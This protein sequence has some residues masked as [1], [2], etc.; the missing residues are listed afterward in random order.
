MASGIDTLRK[1]ASDD[2][3]VVYERE[4]GWAAL[5]LRELWTRH[6]APTSTAA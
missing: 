4:R 5:D 2:E 6:E 3:F 1:S